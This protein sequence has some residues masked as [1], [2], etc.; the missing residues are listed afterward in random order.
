[1]VR[2][3]TSLPVTVTLAISVPLLAVVMGAILRLSFGVIIA[4]IAPLAVLLIV[5]TVTRGRG[6]TAWLRG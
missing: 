5:V 3:L 1:M 2:K 6:G 4:V